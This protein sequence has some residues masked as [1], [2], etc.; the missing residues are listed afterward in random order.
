M[1]N[2]FLFQL[3]QALQSHDL[4]KLRK[5]LESP[6]FNHREDVVKLYEHLLNYR[7]TDYVN[8]DKR[9]TFQTLF[10]GQPYDNRRLNHLFSYLVALIERYFAME[11]V[12]A[13]EPLL[14][15]RQVRALRRRNIGQ[16]F[17]RDVALL[18]RAHAASPYRNAAFYLYEYEL[19]NE[20]FAWEALRTRAVVERVPAAATALANFFMLENLRWASTA[21]SARAVRA[22][23]HDYPVPLADLVLR[24]SARIAEADNPALALLRLAHQSLSEPDNEAAFPDLRAAIDRH[25][26][27]LPPAEARDVFMAAI[28]FA[29]RRH[30]RGEAVYTRE[31]FALYREALERGVLAE[32]GRLPKYTFIN[33]FN[34][35]ELAGAHDWAHT[36]LD[37]YAPLLPETDRD[38]MRRYAL[39]LQHFRQADYARVLELLRAVEFT[40]PFIQLDVRKML[41]RSYF[42]RGEWPALASLL[43]SF[44]TY[45]R[46][47]NDLGYHREGYLNLVRFTKKIARSPQMSAARRAVLIAKIQETQ[48]LTEREWL[49]E[50]LKI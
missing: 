13:D 30:N 22:A 26:D 9:A 25:I 24:E 35:A 14:R 7:K 38:N 45:L 50:K 2:H 39:A 5:F 29:I 32:N 6:Y 47:R 20:R 17:E 37:R 31:A 18:E 3:L 46:R 11:E 42:E 49:L 4:P 21:A 36:F 27:L 41:L 34:L 33:I 43:D 28:N 40:E 1:A 16:Q 15:L 10:P 8:F 12:L 23:S 48:F 44:Q 19:H